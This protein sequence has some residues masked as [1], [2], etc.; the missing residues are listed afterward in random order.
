MIL[1]SDFNNLTMAILRTGLF[2]RYRSKVEPAV[3]ITAD[4]KESI[5]FQY[6]VMLAIFFF[7]PRYS[8]AKP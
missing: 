7:L 5:W 3:F 2:G 4:L 6:L 1:Y 8:P